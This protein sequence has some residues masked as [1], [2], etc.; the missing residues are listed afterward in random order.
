MRTKVFCPASRLVMAE[1]GLT[2]LY[3]RSR[4]PKVLEDIQNNSNISQIENTLENSF[5][6]ETKVAQLTS[7]SHTKMTHE[8]T[9]E[10]LLV[11]NQ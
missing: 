1:C 10:E 7:P 5:A 3:I 11:R 6:N 9:L 8:V 4:I 2:E